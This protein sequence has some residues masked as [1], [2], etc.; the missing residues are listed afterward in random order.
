M[1]KVVSFQLYMFCHNL[2]HSERVFF[3][4]QELEDIVLFG[5]NQIFSKSPPEVPRRL[6]TRQFVHPLSGR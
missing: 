1:V 2:K 4:P 6:T 3:V 5:V